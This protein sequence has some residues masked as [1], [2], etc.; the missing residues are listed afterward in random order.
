MAREP[1]RSVVRTGSS[2]SP[3]R[4]DQNWQVVAVAGAAE[5][6][7][8]GGV[9]QDRRGV[10]LPVPG[11]QLRAG[12]ERGHDRHPAPAHVRGP[13]LQRHRRDQRRLV[14]GQRQRRVQPA[15]R[16]QRGQA[17]GL[18]G[19]VPG[20]R[21]HQRGGLGLLPA[22]QVH[23]R[24][25]REQLGDVERRPVP[26]RRRRPRRG[27]RATPSAGIIVDVIEVRVRSLVATNW[28]TSV[29][30][31][32]SG[33]RR[34]SAVISACP[35]SGSDTQRVHVPHRRPTERGGVQQRGQDAAG[36][37]VPELPLPRP[38]PPLPAVVAPSM[39]VARS[40]AV[41]GSAHPVSG[42]NVIVDGS[43]ASPTALNT[44]TG[45]RSRRSGA[46]RS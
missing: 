32:R 42:S 17:A 13:P 29:S 34:S 1:C 16:L 18:P 5:Q 30:N 28:A 24:P 15:A 14:Q 31:A 27:G 37:G 20:Q 9:V 40:C 3:A 36:L 39:S 6:Q 4:V 21:A 33:E 45:P 41:T 46:V 10:G 19:D 11:E 25:R 7:H 43:P 23:R 8:G 38:T 22:Q 12:L 2:R 44:Y 35:A 26:A